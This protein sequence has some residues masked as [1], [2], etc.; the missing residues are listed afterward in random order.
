MLL[1]RT[2]VKEGHNVTSVLALASYLAAKSQGSIRLVTMEPITSPDGN[3]LFAIPKK[4]RLHEKIV[5]ML[6]GAGIHWVRPQRVDIAVSTNMPITLVFL[7]AADIAAYV[8]EGN[9]D[10]GITGQDIIAETGIEVVQQQPL[11]F[12][13]CVLAV[14]APVDQKITDIAALAGKRIV[15]S[16]PNLARQFFADLEATT[17]SAATRVKYVSGSVEAAC[18]LG[19][20]DAVV[21]LVETGTTMRAAGLEIVAEVMKTQA[22]LISNP[23]TKHTTLVNKINKRISGYLAA[24]RYCML[25]YNFPRE[26]LAEALKI[27][28]GHRS[29][30]VSPLDDESWVAVQAMVNKSEVSEIM[31]DLEAGGAVDILVFNI[32]NCRT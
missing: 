19:L 28:P 8:G 32:E 27:T 4:G 15:T 18:G 6:K 24:K 22:V 29:A 7:P 23:H 25:N 2:V 17:S 5:E 1:K 14:Q 13:K 9:V 30:T 16:F 20:A 10:M 3:L 11:G 31:D 26:K 12:G 21:D